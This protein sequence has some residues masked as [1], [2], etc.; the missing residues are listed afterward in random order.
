LKILLVDPPWY[1]LQNICAATVSLGLASIAGML[2]R[3][4]HEVSLFNGDLYGNGV[5][6]SESSHNQNSVSP[7]K[8]HPVYSR[9]RTVLRQACPD[10]VGITSMTAEFPSACAVARIVREE[11]SG[12]PIIIG[13]VHPTLVP[14]EV[15]GHDLFDYVVIGEGEE[16]AAALFNV[17]G[18]GGNPET[19]AGITYRHEGSAVRTYERPLI[20][21]LDSLPLPS[22]RGLIDRQAHIPADLGGVITSRG[23]P[24]LC[25]YCASKS[26]WTRRVRVR[27]VERVLEEISG[28]YR[29]GVRLFRLQ[30][31]TF[32]I[33]KDRVRIF[34]YGMKAFPDARW[35]CDTRVD[36]LDD[37]LARGMRTAGCYQVN[38]GIESGS[39]RI[40]SKFAKSVDI[41]RARKLVRTLQRY[42]IRVTT[43]FM[44]G[45][46]TETGAELDE[47]LAL[48]RELSPDMPLFSVF[49][50]YPGTELWD[51][52]QRE[53]KLPERPDYGSFYHH[54]EDMNF[55]E[56]DQNDFSTRME[57][58]RDYEKAQTRTARIRYLMRHPMMFLS[59]RNVV[60]EQLTIRFNGRK[61]E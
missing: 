48:A 10:A 21:N 43:Y 4:G 2:E 54:S 13:G 17:L 5:S 61:R 22:Y 19:V 35:S 6:S 33:N 58:V 39:E 30:D 11:R 18:S 12:I 34:C 36:L 7:L 28:L 8:E 47:T 49:T 42:G 57:V 27:S 50:P 20:E 51:S 23:C 25:L 37:D 55:S 15:I 16:T 38:V 24:Y 31:D 29:D 59:D 45:F 40:R 53:G 44:T 56:M 46:P 1:T 9:F 3:R 32:T 60:Q 52:L 26:L 14:E 41:P